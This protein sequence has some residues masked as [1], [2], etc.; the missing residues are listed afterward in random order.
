MAPEADSV[1]RLAHD[2]ARTIHAAFS[3][4][5]AR[6]R[7]ITARAR[8]RFERRDWAGSRKDSLERLHLYPRVLDD[9]VTELRQLLGKRCNRERVW[10][11][12]RRDYSGLLFAESNVEL[13]QTFFNSVT[14]RIFS[15]VGVNPAIEYLSRDPTLGATTPSRNLLAIHRT[16]RG[17]E[18]TLREILA[19]RFPAAAFKDLEGDCRLAAEETARLLS[20][21]GI[22]RTIESVECLKPLFYRD[23]A[24]YVIARVFCADRVLPLVLPLRHRA[25]GVVIDAVLMDE[26][27]VSILF[28]FARSFFHVDA[29][30]PRELIA[31]LKSVIP[32]KPIAELYISLG[33]HR[34]GKTELYRDLSHHL[35]HSTDRFEVARGDPGMVMLVFTLPSYD[36]VF[37]VI[38]D[39]FVYPKMA[40]RRKVRESYR[41]VFQHDRVGRLVDAQEYEHLTFRRYRFDDAL[42]DE[43]Q[44]ECADT[45]SVQADHVSI[46]HLYTER[47]LTPLNLYLRQATEEEA[48]R[49]VI[50]YGL[51]I[52]ELAAANIFPGDFLLKNFGVTRHHRV[53]FYDYDELCLLTD[54]NFRRM[55]PPRTVEEEMAP[56]PW[57]SVAENDVFPEEF[58]RF[59]GL[60]DG[61]R[62]TFVSHHAELFTAEFWR[63]HQ[64]RHRAGEIAEVYPYPATRRLR[65]ED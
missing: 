47:K 25:D 14:R 8:G 35:D 44:R 30:Y 58:R 50:D 26:D 13:A 46:R 54:C 55:P 42:L 5:Q 56:E 15:T 48:R 2:G 34:H 49:A 10:N 18:E 17:L 12:L 22:P 21:D 32:L 61:L 59:L 19:G 4:F 16:T 38:R 39:R 63:E 29:P 57:F 52:K 65:P 9:V 24:A 62:E 27:E 51:A 6:F 23:N 7:E 45:V 1:D 11:R 41:L 33:F 31:F 64:A 20:P 28:S 36:V 3:R 37:K 40:T 60:T 43:L 53:V